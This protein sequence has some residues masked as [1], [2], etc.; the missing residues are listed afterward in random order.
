MAISKASVL[1]EVSGAALTPVSVGLGFWQ[2]GVVPVL[3]V[4]CCDA[5]IGPELACPPCMRACNLQGTAMGG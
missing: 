5:C 2:Q 3:C 1:P 4:F